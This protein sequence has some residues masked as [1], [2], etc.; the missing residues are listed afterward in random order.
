MEQ[1][2]A[3]LCQKQ[4]RHC[5]TWIEQFMQSEQGGSLQQFGTLEALMPLASALIQTEKIDPPSV[6]SD[7][8]DADVDEE[9]CWTQ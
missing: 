4:I 1:V 9:K 7:E 6:P 3:E 5:H 2:T 8:E